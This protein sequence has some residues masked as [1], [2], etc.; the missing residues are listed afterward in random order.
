MKSCSTAPADVWKEQ[1]KFE[2][3][4]SQQIFKKYMS[5]FQ[6]RGAQSVM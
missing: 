2:L 5:H 3:T 1:S 4:K 6:V